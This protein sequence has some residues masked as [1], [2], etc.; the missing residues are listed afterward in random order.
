MINR[1]G[2]QGWRWRFFKIWTVR[3]EM[4][5][6][7]DSIAPKITKPPAATNDGEKIHSITTRVPCVPP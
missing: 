3:A 1:P 6:Y 5:I 4:K 7:L 2:F